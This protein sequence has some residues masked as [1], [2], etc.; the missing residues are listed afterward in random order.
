MMENDSDMD[1]DKMCKHNNNLCVRRQI[2]KANCSFL[3][4][5]RCEMQ[6]QIQKSTKRARSNHDKKKMVFGSYFIAFSIK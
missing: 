1:F 2:R 4:F 5:N 3:S 6:I